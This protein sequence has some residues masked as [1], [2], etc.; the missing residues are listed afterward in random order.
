M[1][2]TDPAPPN[3]DMPDP[4]S[5]ANLKVLADAPAVAMGN[6][7]QATATALALAAQNAIACQQQTMITMQAAT[8]QGVVVLYTLD[9]TSAGVSVDEILGAQQES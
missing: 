8:T 2:M 9:T 7:Y 6:L 4:V 3:G 1:A 5:E